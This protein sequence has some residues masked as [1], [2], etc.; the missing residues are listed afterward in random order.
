M[1]SLSLMVITVCA[2]MEEVRAQKVD[3]SVVSVPEES[4]TK[5]TQ[6]SLPADMVCMPEVKRTAS[7]VG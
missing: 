3:Y 1:F 7:G 6:I 2:P 5:F 4:G